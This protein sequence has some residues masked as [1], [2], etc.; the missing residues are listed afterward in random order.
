[1]III[2]DKGLKIEV[3]IWSIIMK[4]EEINKGEQTYN[5]MATV[6]SIIQISKKIIFPMIE[7]MVIED[8]TERQYLAVTIVI[9]YLLITILVK[10][11][12]EVLEK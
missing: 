4:T 11:F 6:A 12:T 8:K 5:L 9:D 10:I 2:N 3:I 7:E 1:M